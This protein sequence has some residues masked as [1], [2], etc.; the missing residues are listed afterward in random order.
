MASPCSSDPI[1]FLE[2]FVLFLK[3]EKLIV[4]SNFASADFREKQLF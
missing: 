4:S 2:L 3:L 1:I